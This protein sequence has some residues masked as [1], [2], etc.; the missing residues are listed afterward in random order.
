MPD[1]TPAPLTSYHFDLGN[2]T[3]GPIGFCAR[4]RAHS[5]KEAVQ[6]LC[7]ALDSL[8][9]EYAVDVQEDGVEYIEV[10]FNPKYVSESNV[11]DEEDVEEDVEDEGEAAG[12]A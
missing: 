4:I 10:Y 1:E 3:A 6:R 2:S 11:D 9:N 7:A 8:N 12:G 5:K